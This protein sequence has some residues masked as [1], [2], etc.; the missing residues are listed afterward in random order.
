MELSDAR[1]DKPTLL[2]AQVTVDLPAAVDIV[3]TPHSTDAPALRRSG[4]GSGGGG[5]DDNAA[6]CETLDQRV[7]RL[8]GSSL[9]A[10]IA[11]REAEFDARF[12]RA[13]RVPD[14]DVP[15][16]PAAAA[17][18]ET[19]ADADD[20]NDAN[21][22]KP[23]P[24]SSS[25]PGVSAADV[26]EAAKAALSN[27]LGTMGYFAG[28]SLVL[29]R[30][31]PVPGAAPY[32]AGG[33]LPGANPGTTVGR[34]FLA[35]LFTAVPSRSTFPRGFLWD[36]GFHQL[37]V[38]RW[39][40]ALC[41]DALAHWL[42][43]LTAGGWVPREQILGLEARAR[44]PREFVVQRP[45]HGNPPSLMLPLLEVAEDVRRRAA[46]V[47]VEVAAGAGAAG[48]RGGAAA[49]S[50]DGRLVD[51]NNNLAE[52]ERGA[53]FLARAWPRLEAWYGW[54]NRTQ[55]GSAPGAYRWHGRLPVPAPLARA[56]VAASASPSPS[57][58]AAPSA[59]AQAAQWLAAAR[60]ADDDA[61]REEAEEAALSLSAG[62]GGAWLPSRGAG[63]G[64][65]AE[66]NPKTLTSG[67]DDYP[68]AS[69]PSPD[70][71]HLDLRCWM[72]LASRAMAE[73]ARA[74]REGL[75]AVE[76]AR[77]R[78]GGGRGGRQQQA[79]RRRRWRWGAAA[80]PPPPPPAARELLRAAGE[81][82]EAAARALSDLA[83][84]KRLHLDEAS[85]EFRDY[86]LHTDDVRLARAT[87]AVAASSDDDD[88]AAAP[89]SGLR[90]EQREVREEHG[91]PPR[92]GLVPAY[93][94]VSL[95]PL[96][97]G[98]LPPGSPELARQLELLKRGRGGGGGGAAGAQQRG[99]G[100]LWTP[101]G[102]RSLAP[103]SPL[104]RARNTADDPPYWRGQVWINVN[105][106]A[107]RALRR[108]AG[109]AA[110][111]GGGGGGGGAAAAEAAAVAAEAGE[112]ARALRHALLRT[113]AGGY[114][115]TGYFWEQYDDLTGEG[116]GS[117][118][119]T[120]WTALVTLIAAD[121]EDG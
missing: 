33:T 112:A 14:E 105:Y 27:L 72:A 76:A 22:S 83:S 39:D 80:P 46:R 47:V 23:A 34:G 73:V 20:D 3:F 41:R 99:A 78:E 82:Y 120:G 93:G 25:S 19:A 2:F 9:T 58:P 91:A 38:R 21:S 48:G 114:A 95:F 37:L 40:A 113:V 118:P 88:E 85:G 69:H 53:E 54:F 100:G 12:D 71:R 98:L 116:M 32:S 70:E 15:P 115:R 68:R 86:G 109:A 87:V 79:R 66:L 108:Y 24:P 61:A 121:E 65:R 77:G 51:N 49:A 26:K 56:A 104:Y 42:D 52:L 1:E 67:L 17:G 28:R 30:G 10:L 43:L 45:G 111:A 103:S 35:P 75:E 62:G 101:H 89:P 8:S 55:A 44:V 117:R 63:S 64:R 81:R 50:D 60:A 59:A 18:T 31:D 97:T 96:L 6:A 4:A 110:S 102:L 107:L 90:E 74:A 36:E 94:Y 5:D 16:G 57:P 7:A 119:F 84:L 92:P 106:L 29:V 13:F 11:E